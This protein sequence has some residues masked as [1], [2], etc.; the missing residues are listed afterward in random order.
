M[1]IARC[2]T[3]VGAEAVCPWKNPVPDVGPVGGHP[4][5]PNLQADRQHAR[6]YAAGSIGLLS[7]S[8]FGCAVCSVWPARAHVFHSLSSAQTPLVLMFITFEGVDGSGKSTQVRL[9][10][11]YFEERGRV[12][13]L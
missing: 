3:K 7:P 8:S 1:L 5:P 10:G 2:E 12:S 9:L 4:A 11:R 13:L 6:R